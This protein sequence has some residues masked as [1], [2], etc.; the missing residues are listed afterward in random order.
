MTAEGWRKSQFA[1]LIVGCDEFGAEPCQWGNC[2][3]L[4]TICD[5]FPRWKMVLL[6][7]L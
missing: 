6:L 7:G 4:V 2:P 5:Q 3:E 1:E